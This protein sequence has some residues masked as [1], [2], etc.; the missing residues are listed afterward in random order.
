MLNIFF[1]FSFHILKQSITLLENQNYVM[2]MK[3]EVKMKK[4][5][6]QYD[7]D[8]HKFRGKL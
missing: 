4:Y 5:L 8:I 7:K 1:K 3:Y 2:V 6:Y